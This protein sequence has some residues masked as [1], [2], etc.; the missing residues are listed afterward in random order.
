MKKNKAD[1]EFQERLDDSLIYQIQPSGGID[2]R[3]EYY[4]RLGNLYMACVHIHD[5]PAVFTDFWMKR[6]TGRDGATV[7]VDYWTNENV[8][9]EKRVAKSIT[10]LRERERAAKNQA[11]ADNIATELEPIRRLQVALH[12]HDDVMKQVS[13]RVFLYGASLEDLDRKVNRLI[14]DLDSDGFKAALFPDENVDEYKSMY[15]PIDAQMKLPSARE[16]LPLP[17]QIMGLGFSHNQTSLSDPRG[18]YFGVTP[19]GG[20]VY[21]DLF[22]NDQQR[23]YYNTFLSGDLGSGKSTTLKKILWDRASV[24]DMIRVFDRSGEFKQLVGIFNGTV[25]NLDGS[26]GMINMFQVYPTVSDDSGEIDVIASYRAHLGTLGIKYRL[27]DP[28]ADA[29]TA[30]VFASLCDRY[31]Q[32]HHYLDKGAEPITALKNNQYPT[33]TNIIEFIDQAR[34]DEPNNDMQSYYLKILLRLRSL[35]TMYPTMFDGYSD[36]PDL[37][38]V[39]MVSY[40]LQTLDGMNE[41]VQDLAI[42]NALSDSYNDC[43][44]LGRHEKELYDSRQK[45]LSE[46]RHWLIIVDECHTILN[47]KKAFAADFFVKLM[48]EDRKMFGSIVLATQRLERMF[49]KGDNVSDANMSQAINALNQIYSLCQYKILMKHDIATIQTKE[50]PGI[51]RRLFGAVLTESDFSAISTFDRGWCYLL[52]GTDKLQMYFQVPENQIKV[53]AG[54]A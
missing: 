42:Y 26:E 32:E 10:E 23:T 53:F 27:A 30:S 43:M 5:I 40:S 54:G 31:Y 29:R 50:S 17:G 20:T 2:T 39:Q 47:T 4:V 6:I 13:M 37:D 45:D 48:S 8:D 14:R 28:D 18:S 38:D 21:W 11:E 46:V 25:I 16:G 3:N 36:F 24:G 22:H 52:T 19:T 33:L 44:K 7:T 15:L 41:E 35:K 12:Q 9:Y 1:Q 51:L 49:P 34:K